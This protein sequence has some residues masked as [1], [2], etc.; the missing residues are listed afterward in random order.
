[1][2]LAKEQQ[3]TFSYERFLSTL[4]CKTGAPLLSLRRLYDAFLQDLTAYVFPDVLPFIRRRREQGYTLFLLSFGEEAFQRKKVEGAGLSSFFTEILVTSEEKG[5]FI[6][7]R[8]SPRDCV[9]F[10]DDRLQFLLEAKK[11]VPWIHPLLVQ[12]PEGRYDE[13]V[14]PRMKVCFNLNEAEQSFS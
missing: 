10:L 4:A 14:L 5:R 9:W 3:G 11:R 13:E 8:V 2:R 12:R 7:E 6:E 1:M